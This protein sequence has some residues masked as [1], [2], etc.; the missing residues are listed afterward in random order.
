VAGPGRPTREVLRQRAHS[1]ANQHARQRLVE[2]HREEF[3]ELL[4]IEKTREGIPTLQP[5]QVSA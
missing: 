1:R 4:E 5:R 2:Q 3:R